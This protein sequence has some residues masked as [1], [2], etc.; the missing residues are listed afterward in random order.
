[1]S[2]SRPAYKPIA[3]Y[4][5]IGNLR[6]AALV[7]RDG[8][9]DW[10][11]FRHMADPSVFARLLDARR[12]GCF[13][14]S[15]PAAVYGEQR[16]IEHTNVIETVFETVEGRLLVTDFMPL[17]GDIVGK[18][19][20]EAPAEIHRLI[21]CEAGRAD[22]DVEWSPRLN[23]AIGRTDLQA[24]PGGFHALGDRGERLSLGGLPP[25]ARIIDE[26]DG[27]AVRSRF[28]LRSGEWL[29]L[30]T[31]WD[32]DEVLVSPEESRA[33]LDETVRTWRRWSQNDAAAE[34]REWA[35]E[36]GPLVLR[37]ELALK[38]VT[39][40]DSGAFAAAP[41]TSLPEV[42]GGV[43]N[44]D[45]RYAWI[46]DA[47]LTL[48]ALWVAACP[49]EV[50]RFFEFFVTA[51][52]GLDGAKP[53]QILFG[54]GGER[55]LPE[56]ELGHLRGHLDSRPVRVGNQAWEQEQLDVFGEI[57]DAASV[58]A[59]D[60]GT[61]APAVAAFLIDMADRAAGR[62]K[63]P[64]QGIWE[65]RGDPRHYL[66]SKLMCWVALDRAVSMAA[67]LGASVDQVDW[68]SDQR[69][70]IRA[71]PSSNGVGT[72]RSAPS[73]KPWTGPSSMRRR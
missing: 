1:M 34:I 35:G 15:P 54:I 49:D 18:G 31:R 13:R 64:D 16:Y 40:A 9:I 4:A 71:P 12:G 43:R 51:A 44:W 23:Y 3:D 60:V 32:S 50:E 10:C 53:L 62:W 29:S 45:Y 26:D 70:E 6:T 59:D 21:R 52:G 56:S 11:C 67:Q 38:L 2:R 41:T 14:V 22:V 73:P 19:G 36:R 27:P 47:S 25:G 66:Y 48:N 65:H 30:V 24:V 55:R 33:W 8:S 39:H 28:E 72:T 42:I 46:R 5:A 17:R 63:D 69:D 37:S 20:S 57:L 68:W 61:F 7:G 58:F